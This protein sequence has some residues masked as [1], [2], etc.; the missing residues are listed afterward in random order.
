ME[1]GEGGGDAPAGV[2]KDAEKEEKEE[3]GEKA[4]ENEDDG[5]ED[6]L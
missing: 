2:K 6:T 5:V 1:R 4:V 3:D